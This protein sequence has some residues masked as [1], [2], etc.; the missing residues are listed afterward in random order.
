MHGCDH[1]ATWR[2]TNE[3]AS[4]SE[5]RT[6]YN[7]GHAEK[8]HSSSCLSGC[9]FCDSTIQRTGD[10]WHGPETQESYDVQ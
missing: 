10:L 7:Q 5:N 2:K 8:H 9:D 1:R 3:Q 6:T 4:S